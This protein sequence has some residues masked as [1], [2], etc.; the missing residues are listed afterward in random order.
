[1][2]R[3][4]RPE[5]V[6]GGSSKHKKG[7][8]VASALLVGQGLPCFDFLLSLLYQL[9]SLQF[10]SHSA[11]ILGVAKATKTSKNDIVTVAKCN[12]MSTSHL[13]LII[14]LCESPA[15]RPDRQQ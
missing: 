14:P 5:F 4:Y 9:K 13:D 1:M 2:W 6:G 7:Q 12:K 11:A 3:I 8:D 15:P 10:P